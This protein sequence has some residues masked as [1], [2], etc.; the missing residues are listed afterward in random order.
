MVQIAIQ[1]EFCDEEVQINLDDK[2]NQAKL[3]LLN[4]LLHTKHSMLAAKISKNIS[5]SFIESEKAS[6]VY[7]SHTPQ[8]EK[9][10]HWLVISNS[11][12]SLN[13]S[14]NLIE[15]TKNFKT[16]QIKIFEIDK[17]YNPKISTTNGGGNMLQHIKSPK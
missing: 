7:D 8:L 5:T 14:S 15:S 6:I 10:K 3:D 4:E 11:L 16:P 1:K 2:E 13:D 17:V 12:D 9:K